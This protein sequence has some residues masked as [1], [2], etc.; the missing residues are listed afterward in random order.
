MFG[1]LKQG[2]D[3]CLPGETIWMQRVASATLAASSLLLIAAAPAPNPTGFEGLIQEYGADSKPWWP[4]ETRAPAGAPNVLIW[5]L[6]DAGFGQLGAF[7]GLIDTPNID[8]LADQGLRYTNFHSTA[9]C[10]P[11]RA[12]LL[13]GRNHHAVGVGSH[14]AAPAGFPGYYGRVAPSAGSLAKILGANGYTTYAAGKWDQV[15]GEAT[16]ISGPFDQWPSGQGFD[17]FYGFLAADTNNFLPAMWSDHTPIEP[18]LARSDYHLSTD[19]A[20]KAIEWISGQASTTPSRPFLL[21]WATGAVH[22]PHHAPRAFIDKYKGRFDMGWDKAREMVL[23]RQKQLGVVPADTRLPPRP[24]QLP[25]WDSLGPAE[26]R[27]AAHQM[28]VFAAQLEHADFEFGRVIEEL[29]RTGQLDNT[30]VIVTSDNGASGEGGPAGSYNEVRNLVGNL[31]TPELNAPFFDAW[32][33]PTVHNT[34]SAAW[35]FAGNTPFNYYKQSTHGGGINDPMV[36][37]WPSRITDKG[38]IRG[39]FHHLNDVTPTLL[40]AIGVSPPDVLD[41]VKQQPMDGVSMAYSFAQPKAPSP[42]R[43][44]YFELFGNRAIYADGWKAVAIANP[45]PWNLG[46]VVDFSKVKWELYNLNSDINERIDLA[47]REPRKL[48]EML[49]IFDA[50]AR[51]NNV[52]PIRPDTRA[53]GAEIERANLEA[54]SGRYTFYPPGAVRLPYLAAA[55]TYG[56]SFTLTADVEIPAGGAEGVLAAQGGNTGGFALYLQNGRPVFTHNYFGETTYDLKGDATLASGPSSIR[57]DFELQADGSANARLFVNDELVGQSKAPRTQ[58]LTSGLNDNFDIGQDSGSPV[59]PSYTAPF[60][61]TGKLK[62]VVIDIAPP[63]RS[64]TSRAASK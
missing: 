49:A 32:G 31:A 58:R 62:K 6:D 53:R 28:E 27:M 1:G 18:Q 46:K 30:I 42:K 29:R 55:P 10:S 45:T 4:A 60:R 23:A 20:D 59:S 24:P 61:F 11:S 14:S 51:R 40:D 57:A 54:R 25:A 52:Y 2:L 41:G 43:V 13:T 26:K 56:H 5:L 19:M 35:A 9:L 63:W 15:P 3:T 34:Y 22:A 7:G 47:R 44:Q 36:I 64:T 17:H 48:A 37:S 21:Y 12:A 50:E 39:Q 38:S 33:G 16:S 8:R